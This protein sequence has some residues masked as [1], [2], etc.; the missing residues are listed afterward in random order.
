MSIPK[1]QELTRAQSQNSPKTALAP[2]FKNL[3]LRNLAL[4]QANF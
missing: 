1:T 3:S 2:P 4:V